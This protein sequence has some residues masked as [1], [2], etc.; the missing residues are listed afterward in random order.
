MPSRDAPRWAIVKDG[1]KFQQAEALIAYRRP[2]H[3]D[4][5]WPL[6]VITGTEVTLSRSCAQSGCTNEHEEPDLPVHPVPTPRPQYRCQTAAA[7]AKDNNCTSSS[8]PVTPA[9][10]SAAFAQWDLPAR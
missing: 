6:L 10:A 7:L 5:R 1:P 2:I 3:D 4:G 8:V 9:A